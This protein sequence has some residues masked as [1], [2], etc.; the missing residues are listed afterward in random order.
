MFH[1]NLLGVLDPRLPFPTAL[2]TESGTAPIHGAVHG[3][4]EWRVAEQ[5]PP[6]K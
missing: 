2:R 5:R 4:A 3:L 6:H 1:G